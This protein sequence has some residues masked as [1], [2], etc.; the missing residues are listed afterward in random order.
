MVTVLFANR[1]YKILQ[2]ELE[3]VGLE[4]VSP[5]ARGQFELTPS[6]LDWVKLANG[7]GVPA[8]RAE[9]AEEFNK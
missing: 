4:N 3:R 7:M 8:E 5:T 6:D 9:S 2:G 1:S